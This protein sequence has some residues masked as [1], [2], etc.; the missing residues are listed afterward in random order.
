MFG[1][2][3][4]AAL[5]DDLCA[6]NAKI[7]HL[8]ALLNSQDRRLKMLVVESG[9]WKGQTVDYGNQIE[10]WQRK[11]REL[12]EQMTKESTDLDLRAYADSIKQ[13]IID[14]RPE[15]S[16]IAAI[17]ATADKD[18]Q[19]VFSPPPRQGPGKVVLSDDAIQRLGEF[20]PPETD[21]DARN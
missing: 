18:V 16:T 21:Y 1:R 13:A 11:N 14:A 4:K 2:K 9:F 17:I 3:T 19:G 5:L 6:A 20:R 15:P 10:F 7:R 12:L 8:D